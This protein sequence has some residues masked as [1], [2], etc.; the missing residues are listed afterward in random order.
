MKEIWKDVPNYEGS[1]QVS[2]F[3]NVQSFVKN[4]KGAIRALTQSKSGH[5]W[6]NL[7]RGTNFTVHSLVLTAFIGERPEGTE[8]CHCDGNP[9][10]NTLAN[11]RWDT[12]TENARDMYR[13]KKHRN[14]KLS[15]QAVKE[16]K[17]LLAAS[18]ERGLLSKLA[19]NYGVSISA[20]SCIKRG[21]TYDYALV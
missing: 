17:I 18:K 6:V 2:N 11:L 10:N 9:A 21:V 7:G 5:L 3:G 12:H 8:C 1:Y 4:K 19:I 20:I 16:I 15:P 13:H 14:Q